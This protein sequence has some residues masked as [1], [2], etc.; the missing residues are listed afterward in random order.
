MPAG[1]LHLRGSA[2]TGEAAI[3]DFAPIVVL[4]HEW[5]HHIQ[6][7]LGIAPRPG[8]TFEWHADSLGQQPE[9]HPPDQ[10]TVTLSLTCYVF[11]RSYNRARWQLGISLPAEG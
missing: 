5:G 11:L 10:A 3:G 6:T 4:A 2:G 1:G 8:N 7:V 9:L